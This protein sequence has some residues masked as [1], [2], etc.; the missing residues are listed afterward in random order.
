MNPGAAAVLVCFLAAGLGVCWLVRE[1]FRQGDLP[2]DIHTAVEFRSEPDGRVAVDA[3][4][5]NP[6]KGPVVVQ[7][8]SGWIG[9]LHPRTGLG[10]TTHRRAPRSLD[11]IVFPVAGHDIGTLSWHLAPEGRCLVVDVY[12]WQQTSRIRRHRSVF[13]PVPIGCRSGR[14]RCPAR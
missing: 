4:L 1:G 12:V 3:W 10:P 9:R 7:V 6:G 13:R 8:V 5:D 11:G 2:E 14:S